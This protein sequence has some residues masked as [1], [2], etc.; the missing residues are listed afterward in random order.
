MAIRQKARNLLANTVAA[1]QGFVG[2]LTG[3]VTGNVTGNLTGNVTGDVTGNV[4]GNLTGKIADSGFVAVSAD[5]AIA[6][7]S[8]DTVYYITK[9]TACAMTLV[10]PTATTHD[11]RKL[12]FISTTAAAH[13]LDNSAGSGFFSTGGSTK[14]V[15]TFGAS[16]ANGLVLYAYQGKWYIDPRG[17]TGIT[18]G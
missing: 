10:D 6:V 5:G 8:Q 18:L 16:I 15:A 1:A 4:S 14:D 12:T 3:N 7:P 2:N 13:T 11:N 9:G 17:N